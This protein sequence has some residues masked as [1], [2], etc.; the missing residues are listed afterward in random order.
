MLRKRY[1]K[2]SLCNDNAVWF[3]TPS[4]PGRTCF[5]DEHVPRG[6]TC[7][8]H[9]IEEFEVP[10]DNANIMWWTKDAVDNNVGERLDELSTSVRNDDSYYFEELDELGRRNPCCE[11]MYLPDGDEIEQRRY[12]ISK[13]DIIYILERSKY[14]LRISDLL[15]NAV[16]RLLNTTKDTDDYNDFMQ[17]MRRT[18]EPYFKIGYNGRMSMAFYFSFRENLR[19]LR[20]KIPFNWEF[21][22]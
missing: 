18:C 19:E 1:R 3:Y 4:S 15:R 16:I 2:C 13:K 21:A 20:T 17:R 11:F 7:N 14:K 12:S 9:N 5:C 8:L 6:C 22:L 10:S